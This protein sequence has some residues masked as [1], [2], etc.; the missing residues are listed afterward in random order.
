MVCF[1]RW[2][3][4]QKI[5]GDVVA[6][7]VAGWS[8][9]SL[10]IFEVLPFFFKIVAFFCGAC[11]YLLWFVIIMSS[12][13]GLIILH[14]WFSVV[15]EWRK[16]WKEMRFN[17]LCWCICRWYTV[18]NTATVFC[19]LTWSDENIVVKNYVKKCNFFIFGGHFWKKIRQLKYIDGENNRL[20]LWCTFHHHMA[21]IFY[22]LSCVFSFFHVFIFFR[23]IDFDPKRPLHWS[24]ALLMN[25]HMI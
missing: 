5:F 18:W 11:S 9:F 4:T 15:G 13:L 10:L 7:V 1:Q 20:E 6:T 25:I 23:K 19:D 22:S 21:C 24:V 8:I 16:K 3:N 2:V 17:W 12:A 14:F